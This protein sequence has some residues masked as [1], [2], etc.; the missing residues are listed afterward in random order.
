MTSVQAQLVFVVLGSSSVGASPVTDPYRA[1]LQIWCSD[2]VE[3]PRITRLPVPSMVTLRNISYICGQLC[4]VLPC[5]LL[6][7]FVSIKQGNVTEAGIIFQELFLSVVH[8]CTKA[9]LVEEHVTCQPDSDEQSH[10]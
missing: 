10:Y 9:V 4:S 6:V 7:H 3:F 2:T 8:R 1:I 5:L